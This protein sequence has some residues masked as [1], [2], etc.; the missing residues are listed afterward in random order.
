MVGTVCQGG[1]TVPAPSAG[2]KKSLESHQPTSAKHKAPSVLRVRGQQFVACRII[3]FGPLTSNHNAR[4]SNEEAEEAGRGDA[5]VYQE[6]GRISATTAVRRTG[7]P[8][9]GGAHI[10]GLPPDNR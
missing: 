8:G 3:A 4:L 5:S 9:V 2:R 7:V 1:V 6:E 10:A